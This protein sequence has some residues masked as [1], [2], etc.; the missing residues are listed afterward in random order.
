MGL[1]YLSY[2][3]PD[4]NRDVGFPLAQGRKLQVKDVE[5]K[6]KITPERPAPNG[7]AKVLIGGRDDPD[8]HLYLCVAPHA[9][10]ATVLQNAQESRLEL[11]RHL[12]D[13]V[14]EQRPS[15]GELEHAPAT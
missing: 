6:V 8:I 13:L 11:G 4:E 14:Q 12:P 15:I 5:A 3:V 10:E 1:T 9:H 7:F 2:E